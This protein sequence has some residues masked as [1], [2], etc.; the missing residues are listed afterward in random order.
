MTSIVELK[1]RLLD[2][3]KVNDVVAKEL[4]STLVGEASQISEEDFK[5][6]IKTP[7]DDK[8]MTTIRKFLKNA[9][10]MKRIQCAE[11]ERVIGHS[12]ND[13]KTY[14]VSAEHREFMEHFVHKMR[15]TDREIEILSGYLPKQLT[16][17]ELR[18]IISDYKAANI[19][20]NVGLIMAFLK[21]KYNGLYDGK[22]ASQIAKT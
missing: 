12:P 19:G 13:M 7:T 21:S 20:A 14:L 3:R 11:F 22:I 18:S 9:T 8:V 1:A 4:L 15:T 17:D 5:A 10:E 6:G 2:A 16:E